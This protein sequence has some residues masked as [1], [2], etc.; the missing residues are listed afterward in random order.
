MSVNFWNKARLVEV[1]KVLKKHSYI[2]EAAYE[3]TELFGV[4]ITPSTL[5]YALPKHYSVRPGDLLKDPQSKYKKRWW[6]IDKM[7]Q[8]KKIMSE[9][10]TIHAAL[11]KLQKEFKRSISEDSLRTAF[12]RMEDTSSLIPFLKKGR[13]RKKL[14]DTEED[15]EMLI[16]I[17]KKHSSLKPALKEIKTKLNIGTTSL[18]KVLKHH[19][20]PTASPIDFMKGSI[21]Q[22]E[23]ESDQVEALVK[24][25]KGRTNKNTFI[26]F[27]ELCDIMDLSP[28]KAE[29]LIDEGKALGYTLNI[30]GDVLYLDTQIDKKQ[31][32]KHQVAIPKE[33]NK[34]TFALISDTHCGSKHCMKE[35]MKHFINTCYNEYGITTIFHS[36]DCLAGNKVY[37]GQPAELED[38]SCQGQASIFAETLPQLKGLEYT[39]V[40]GNHDID[41]IK[42]NGADPAF[43]INKMREDV[44]FIGNIKGRCFLGDTGIEMELLHV[45]STARVRSYAPEMHVFRSMSPKDYAHIVAAGHMHSQ[46]YFQVQDSHCFLVP[47]WEGANYFIKYFDLHP[48]IGGI[49]VT[50]ILDDE[51]NIIRCD[52]S[53]HMYNKETEKKEIINIR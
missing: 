10:N 24:I 7:N 50:L 43:I 2:S 26:A 20:G 52:N 19:Y 32:K 14:D 16:S 6:T 33:K 13:R 39:A 23:Q 48:M 40:L 45:K 46:G 12:T 9:C 36:G 1:K 21:A 30:S 11:I 37:K 28:K 22:I 44:T 53:F 17:L 27:R 18:R 31:E 51:N 38:W 41:F 5:S 29:S 42:S 35:E 49:V 4:P 3:L 8:A 47:S 34:L 15:I 25:V